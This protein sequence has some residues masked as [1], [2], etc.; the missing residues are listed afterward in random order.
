MSLMGCVRRVWAPVGI[1]LTQVV[2]YTRQW[3]YLDLAV[4]GVKGKLMWAWSDNMKAE[5]IVPVVKQWSRRRVKF[6]VWY[7][8]RGH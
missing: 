6:L 8:A 3:A 7:R 4:N 2:E 5:S 1:K